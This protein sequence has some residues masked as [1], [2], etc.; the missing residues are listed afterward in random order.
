MLAE[1]SAPLLSAWS[2]RKLGGG[3]GLGL[4]SPGHSKVL[5]PPCCCLCNPRKVAYKGQVRE[6]GQA[7]V[8]HKNNKPPFTPAYILPLN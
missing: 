3:Q 8:P 1:A 7:V 5:Y 2:A 6:D 4:C